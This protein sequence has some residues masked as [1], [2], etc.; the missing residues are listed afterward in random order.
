MQTHVWLPVPYVISGNFLSHAQ[1]EIK[2][3]RK[4]KKKQQPKSQ[5]PKRTTQRGPKAPVSQSQSRAFNQRTPNQ[6]NSRSSRI[7]PISGRAG[8]LR[9][10]LSLF[11]PRPLPQ[12]YGRDSN[13][14]CEWEPVLKR[15][16]ARKLW[17]KIQNPRREPTQTFHGHGLDT[18]VQQ[19]GRLK[20][21][22]SREF[23]ANNRSKKAD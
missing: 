19:Q 13:S 14:N 3:E 20:G 18:L 2:Q 16:Q 17:Q 11:W 23:E 10:Q 15:R 8:M 21:V 7:Q 1:E 5:Q 9:G 6:W 12:D 22:F 4:K